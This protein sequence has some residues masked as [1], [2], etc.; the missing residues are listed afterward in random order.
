MP[1]SLVNGH[2]VMEIQAPLGIFH[3]QSD[4][5]KYVMQDPGFLE[6][7]LSMALQD[8]GSKV[9]LP[10]SFHKGHILFPKVVDVAL[11]LL[12]PAGYFAIGAF[13]AWGRL[14]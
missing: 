8:I 12:E 2:Q 5:I 6:F 11:A 7:P 13:G 1:E 14:V 9:V 4:H 10:Q 3:V